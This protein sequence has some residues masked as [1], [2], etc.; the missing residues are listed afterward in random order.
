MFKL[1]L[2]KIQKEL[3]GTPY[4]LHIFG[5]VI[6]MREEGNVQMS[7]EVQSSVSEPSVYSWNSNT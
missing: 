2:C 7:F 3:I 5:I 4:I 6:I 1:R